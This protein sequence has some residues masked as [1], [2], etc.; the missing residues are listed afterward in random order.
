MND[1][2]V[3]NLFD[4][5]RRHLRREQGRVAIRRAAWLS[6]ASMLL[7]GVVHLTVLSVPVGAVLF[8]VGLVW[9]SMLA[10]VAWRR[11]SDSA[12]ALWIDRHLGGASAFTTLLD[13]SSRSKSPAHTQ[14]VRW[15]EQWAA[16]KVPGFLRSLGAQR[17]SVRVSGSLLSMAVCAALALFLLTLPDAVPL[18]RRQASAA[19]T[20]T[21]GDNATPP[22][23][24]PVTARLASEISS[25]L[26]STETPSEPEHKGAGDA[27]PAGAT[28]PDDDSASPTPSS[29]T[30]LPSDAS[31]PRDS[32]SI[33]SVD[34]S[35][36]AG[37]S[38][39][40][41]V[42]SGRDAGDSPDT[43]ADVGVSRS[44]TG[45]IPGQRFGSRVRLA[46]SDR[47]ADMDQA[48]DFNES[49]SA[50]GNSVPVAAAAVAAATPPP[51]VETAR[52]SPTETSYVQAWMKATGRSR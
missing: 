33:A 48:G 23:E 18:S 2:V 20:A 50:P 15:L 37:Q 49:V 26:R 4:A 38:R 16:A 7:A 41:D 42:V 39:S 46:A 28:R 11:P 21:A 32:R 8:V 12:C 43:R 1:P 6:A 52:L 10:W 45:T 24:A 51:A 22:A 29:A 9:I 34:A 31:T 25:A 3:Q 27:S 47:R 14:A 19:S 35:V 44:P 30:P 40:A 17:P 36:A 5:T 13:P